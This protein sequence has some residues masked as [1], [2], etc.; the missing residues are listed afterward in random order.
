MRLARRRGLL[1]L[2]LLAAGGCFRDWRPSARRAW[3]TAPA[4]STSRTRRRAAAEDEEERGEAGRA[5]FARMPAS[6]HTTVRR[7]V[8]R[9]MLRA[10]TW[11]SSTADREQRVVSPVLAKLR[12]VAR[13][14]EPTRGVVVVCGGAAGL[15]GLLVPKMRSLIEH[16]VRAEGGGPRWIQS[17]IQ[18]LVNYHTVYVILLLP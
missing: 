9:R 2:R 13:L 16:G 17:S 12:A 11:G 3:P 15:Y 7:G 18:Y 5:E 8:D 6:R 4:A 10:V 14:T 1:L